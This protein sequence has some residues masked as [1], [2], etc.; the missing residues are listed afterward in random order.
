MFV[1]VYLHACLVT[2]REKTN[3]SRKA[4]RCKEAASPTHTASV[5]CGLWLGLVSLADID[6]ACLSAVV[7]GRQGL[8]PLMWAIMGSKPQTH[9]GWKGW[10]ASG[11]VCAYQ[12]ARNAS[13]GRP[14]KKR[15]KG[16]E[17]SH[18]CM[19]SCCLL[20]LSSSYLTPHMHV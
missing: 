6:P 4:A 3:R 2:R 16:F 17:Q 1:P 18:D 5:L 19:S 20:H 13:L 9:K 7:P 8:P 15:E 10:K 12:Q 14:A 11:R